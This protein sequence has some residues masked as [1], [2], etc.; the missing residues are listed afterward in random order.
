MRP[1]LLLLTAALGGLSMAAMISACSASDRPP[2]A[3]NAVTA[4]PV[5]SSSGSSGSAVVDSGADGEA[6]PEADLCTPPAQQSQIVGEQQIPGDPPAPSGGVLKP[7][8][9]VLNELQSYDFMPDGGSDPPPPG[10]TGNY[11]R[12]TMMVTSQSI[13]F[14]SSAGTDA[15][16]LPTDAPRIVTYTVAGTSL[17]LTDACTSSTASSDLA[18]SV[19]ENLVTFYVAPRRLEVFLLK[20]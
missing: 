2:A 10:P 8:L 3:G 19:T 18:F 1:V 12:A 6:G 15:A 17:H 4:M 9:Y 13:R 5:P 14:L 11:G 16:A 7:G 20:P